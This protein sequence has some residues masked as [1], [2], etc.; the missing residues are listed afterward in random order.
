[1]EEEEPYAYWFG[2][3][4][5]EFEYHL[6]LQDILLDNIIEEYVNAERLDE[7]RYYIDL[8]KQKPND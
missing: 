5:T 4:L 3:P 6:Y 8:I 2:D 7:A 1:M